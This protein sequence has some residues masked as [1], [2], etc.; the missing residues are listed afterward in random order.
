[1][2]HLCQ[3]ALITLMFTNKTG[4]FGKKAPVF[5][6][7]YLRNSLFLTFA[8]KFA[9]KKTAGIPPLFVIYIFFPKKG[10]TKL[11]FGCILRVNKGETDAAVSLSFVD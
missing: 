4:V 11:L 3:F 7:K 1:M 9:P 5:M 10:L 6:Q 2:V 8:P